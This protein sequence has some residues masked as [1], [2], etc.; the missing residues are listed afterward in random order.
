MSRIGTISRV[1]GE[2]DIKITI[3]LDVSEDEINA[4]LNNQKCKDAE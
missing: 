3:N 2:T 4:I 1:T